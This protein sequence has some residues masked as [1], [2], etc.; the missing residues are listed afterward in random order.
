MKKKDND[1]IRNYYETLF[2]T[3]EYLKSTYAQNIYGSA[4][5]QYK[6]TVKSFFSKAKKKTQSKK[7]FFKKPY[8]EELSRYQ[9][10]YRVL[11]AKPLLKDEK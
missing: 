7:K 6:D 3:E 11:G 4:N 9:L 5:S 1:F 8:E 10:D 2:Q